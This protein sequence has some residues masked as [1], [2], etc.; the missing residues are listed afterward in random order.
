MLKEFKDTNECKFHEHVS[1][2]TIKVQILFKVIY[3]FNATPNI[4]LKMIFAKIEAPI[5]KFV[6][7][8]KEPPNSQNNSE[9]EQDPVEDSCILISK[10]LSELW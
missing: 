1:E 7:N 5:L 10:L 2:D 9:K 8:H 6:W 4:I 3:R